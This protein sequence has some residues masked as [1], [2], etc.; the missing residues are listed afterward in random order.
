MKQLQLD[1]NGNPMPVFNPGTKT[2]NATIKVDGT[3]ASAATTS[4]I[5]ATENTVVR[6]VADDDC[7]I[8]I[9]TTPTATTGDIPLIA[10]L[11]EYFVISAGAKIAVLGANLY[12][13]AH[14]GA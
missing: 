10:G 12:I 11:P 2:A 1:P 13:T 14:T 6:L 5:H 8:A 7:H 3:S 4:A 9:D